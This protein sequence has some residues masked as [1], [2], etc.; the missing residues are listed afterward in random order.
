MKS[1]RRMVLALTV[2][3]TAAATACAQLPGLPDHRIPLIERPWPADDGGKFSFVI[4]GDKTSGGEGKWPIYDR[5][6]E[7]I[8][9]LAPDFVI[10]VGDQIPGHMEERAPW[11]AEWAEYMDHARRIEAPLFLV[12]GNHDIA[13]TQCYQF[14]QEDFGRTYYAFTYRDCLFLALNTEEERFDGRGPVWQAMMQFAEHELET[15]R[16]A[17]HTF[18]FFHKPMWDDPRFTDDWARLTKALGRRTFTAVAGHEHYLMSDRQDGNLRVIQSATGGGIGENAL[19]QMGAFHS[20]ALVT[21]DGDDATYAVVEPEGG[22]WPVD[23]APASFRHAVSFNLLTLDA[24]M[25]EG[26]GEAESIVHGRFT[27]HNVLDKPIT[28]RVVVTPLDQCGWRAEGGGWTVSAKE[29]AIEQALNVGEEAQLSLDFRVAA[30]DLAT[31]PVVQCHIQYDGHWLEDDTYPMVEMNT[32]PLYPRKTYHEVPQWQITGP[33]GIGPIDTDY[34]PAEPE[35]ANAALFKMLGP[36]AG[37]A[38]GK[39]YAGGT[40]WQVA[41]PLP[42]GLL[43]FNGLMGTR[44]L[45]A[46]YAACRVHSNADQLVYAAVYADNYAQVYLNGNL[47]R[48]GQEFNPPGGFSYVPLRLRA[49][50]N[51]LVVKLINNRGDW[52]LRFLIAD[53]QG[54]LEFSAGE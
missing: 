14:W 35:K 15:H 21:V 19:R 10:T 37:Y 46:A 1:L 22:V 27:V 52:F 4:L 25:P 7:A 6:V 54:N 11:D 3:M 32:V 17:R 23:I 49:G 41:D 36:E 20:F 31:P 39:T 18:L 28:A 30:A 29:A 48:E 42:N 33:F 53:P 24:A 9:L 47:V 50:L 26:I 44:D 43:N 12:P 34:L 40:A 5:A 2:S 51:D 38:A 13:N 16:D 45:A 8:N